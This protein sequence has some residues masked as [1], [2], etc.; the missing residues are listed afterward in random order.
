MKRCA[1]SQVQGWPKPA[2]SPIAPAMSQPQVPAEKPFPLGFR[3]FVALVA[4]LM[5]I[6][7]LSTDPMLPALPAIGED[8]GVANPNHRQWVLIAFFAGAGIGSLFFGS[9]S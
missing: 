9:L 7:A 5:A 8:L 4:C 2:L 1:Y 3:E 6:N